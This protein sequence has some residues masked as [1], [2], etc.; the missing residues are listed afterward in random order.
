MRIEFEQ[1]EDDI[2]AAAATV[3]RFNPGTAKGRRTQR[4]AAVLT[5][6]VGVVC[7]VLFLRYDAELART[8]VGATAVGL[9]M[10]AF[11]MW[12]TAGRTRANA[13]KYARRAVSAPVGYC[14]LG[15]RTYEVT[16]DALRV[17]SPYAESRVRWAAVGYVRRDEDYLFISIAGGSVF[18]I[19]RDAFES[20]TAFDQF[21][22]AVEV[23]HHAAA[24]GGGEHLTEDG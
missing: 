20:D 14:L 8:V 18:P 11:Q 10:F 2:A 6:T 17:A 24:G 4:I 13:R 12:P 9:V 5:G 19:P 1:T 15:P 3:I 21:A 16:P 23:A 7:G 22:G